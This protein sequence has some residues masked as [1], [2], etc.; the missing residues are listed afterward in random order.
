MQPPA[1]RVWRPG[2]AVVVDQRGDEHG[3][4]DG[5]AADATRGGPVGTPEAPERVPTVSGLPAGEPVVALRGVDVRIGQT[6]ILGN[7]EF[8]AARG[9]VVALLGVNGAGKSTTLRTLA[10][11]LRPVTGQVTLNG[12]D[13]TRLR[14]EQRVTAGLVM[15]PGGKGVFGSST[16]ADNLRTAEWSARRRKRTAELAA[17]HAGF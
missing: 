1:V 15:A 16:V 14:A 4:G 10:G 7:V 3:D 6:L 17:A 9:E 12:E 5:A 2:A 11:A 13:V 8:G